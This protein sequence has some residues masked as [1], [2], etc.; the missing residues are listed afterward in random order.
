MYAWTRIDNGQ[1]VE[2]EGV[3]GEDPEQQLV[4]EGK[5]PLTHLCPIHSYSSLLAFTQFILKDWLAFG[6][7]C[8]CLP[9]VVGLFWFSLMLVLHINQWTWWEYLWYIVFPFDYDDILVAFKG[10]RAVSRVPLRKDWFVGWP[11][12]K[13][14]A[15]MRVEWDALS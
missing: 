15:N 11:P 5:C 12:G 1:L 7:C 14:S 8:P 4:G 13:N 3:A 2:S 6:L 9:M 10:T